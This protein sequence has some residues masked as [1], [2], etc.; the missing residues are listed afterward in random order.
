MLPFGSS[1]ASKAR[2]AVEWGADAGFQRSTSH[3]PPN[4]SIA[5]ELG[6]R[7]GGILSPLKVL[8]LRENRALIRSGWRRGFRLTTNSGTEV[9]PPV[10]VDATVGL[11]PP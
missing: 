4:A 1:N 10:S 6:R 7:N 2:R 9:T 8:L 11:R 5:P 3:R